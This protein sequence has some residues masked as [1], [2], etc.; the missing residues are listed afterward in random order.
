MLKEEQV[1]VLTLMHELE[2]NLGILYTLFSEK[3]PNYSKLWDH[4]SREEQKHAEEVRKLYQNSYNGQVIFEKGDIKA[5]HVQSIIDYI[6]NVNDIAM[7]GQLTAQKALSIT[8]DFE[9]SVLDKSLFNHFEVALPFV[10][11]IEGLRTESQKHAL[12]AK[13]ELDKFPGP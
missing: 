1:H 12:M 6:K 7:R 10:N 9:S 4:L 11:V 2:K 13:E 5:E 3:F 8:Y